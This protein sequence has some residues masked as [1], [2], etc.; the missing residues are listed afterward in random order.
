ML[1]RK[2]RD[3]LVCVQVAGTFQGTCRTGIEATAAGT[4]TILLRG[5]VIQFQ[6]CDDLSEKEK[7]AFTGYNQVGILPNPAKTGFPGPVTLQNGSRVGEEAGDRKGRVSLSP[8]LTR[9]R[10]GTGLRILRPKRPAH[11]R[12]PVKHGD[13]GCYVFPKLPE[14]VFHNDMI[15]LPI[16]II[17]NARGTGR[18]L[19]CRIVIKGHGNNGTGTF[20]QPRRIEPD[21]T[22]VLHIFHAGMTSFGYPPVK[23][24]N[25]GV[26]G[27]HFSYSA[28]I[29]A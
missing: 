23:K 11:L 28:G 21:I 6:G 20:H 9:G 18:L 25:F 4:A 13:K 5:V 1:D 17:G 16:S 7:G 27:S 19:L 15:V 14:F 22:V 29:E 12:P 24:Q 2:V 8:C 3:A 10:R 26:C